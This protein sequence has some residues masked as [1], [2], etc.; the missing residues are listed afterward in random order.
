MRVGECMK[1]IERVRVRVFRDEERLFSVKTSRRPIQLMSLFLEV[2][3]LK[4]K[5]N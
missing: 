5:L 3:E 1:D 2:L 4:L